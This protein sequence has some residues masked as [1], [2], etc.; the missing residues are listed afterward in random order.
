MA[1][2]REN[3]SGP[4]EIEAK[5]RVGDLAA[6]RARLEELGA[7]KRAGAREHNVVFD[8]RERSLAEADCL[9][10]LRRHNTTVLTFKGPREDRAEPI[11]GRGELEV[12]VSSFETAAS[13]LKALGFEPTWVYEKD[14][15]KWSLD[16][17]L[18]MLDTLPR[19]GSFVEVEAPGEGRVRRILDMLGLSPQSCETR[20][21]A[22]ILADYVEERGEPFAD[23]VFEEK[24]EDE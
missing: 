23:L 14:R 1:E 9:L 15:E 13:I 5:V 10:R 8:T 11:K 20:T 3:N 4:R 22:E 7:C 17:A 19:L 21:Y 6:V 24:M 18:V 2:K 12:E 16:D